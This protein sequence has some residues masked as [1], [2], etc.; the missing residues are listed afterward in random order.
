MVLEE[1][2]WSDKYFE[3]YKEYDCLE[4]GAL[5]GLTTRYLSKFFNRVFVIDPWDGRQQGVPSKYDIFLEN[6]KDLP[7]VFHC[8]T[9]SETQIAREFLQKQDNLRLG[10]SFIDGLHTADAVVNDWILSERW[11]VSGGLIFID[12]CDFTPVNQGAD[13]VRNNFSV[14]Y[15]ELPP[16]NKSLSVWNGSDTYL[17]IFKKK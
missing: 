12:D 8:R 14:T 3:D 6:T 16:S 10:F 7:N 2:R 4:I 9:G 13:W 11:L 17:R 15:D 1:V 5:D